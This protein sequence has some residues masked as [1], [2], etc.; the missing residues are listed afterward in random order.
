MRFQWR[1]CLPTIALILVLSALSA[2]EKAVRIVESEIR[3]QILEKEIRL[4]VPVLNDSGAS[5]SGT[6]NIELLDPNDTI[7]VSSKETAKLKPDRNS[8]TV[9]LDNSYSKNPQM[10]WYRV[11]YRF[12]E[13]NKLITSGMM[14]KKIKA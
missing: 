12:H 3:A 9:H 8:V 6:L 5:I 14:L 13:G 11:R 4:T 1:I 2:A 7:V 10:P